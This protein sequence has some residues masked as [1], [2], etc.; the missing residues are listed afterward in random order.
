[1]INNFERF[2]DKYIISSEQYIKL[3]HLLS[4]YGH[5][6]E[7][8]LYP[9]TSYYLDNPKFEFANES[10]LHPNDNQK[11]RIRK[12]D[13][14]N[15]CLNK[16][17]IFE[18][19]ERIDGRIYKKRFSL[20]MFDLFSIS[21]NILEKMINQNFK[22]VYS[23]EK[24]KNFYPRILVQYFREA[25]EFPKYKDLRI[26]FDCKINCYL[27]SSN[28]FNTIITTPCSL[29]SNDKYLLEIKYSNTK[30]QWLENIISSVQIEKT[31]F[32]KYVSAYRMLFDKISG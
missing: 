18:L 7:Y 20:P 29:L 30:P 19:K 2:E 25:Y 6:D 4:I 9:V 31:Y 5:I 23:E 12:Y 26:T 16:S 21:D 32:S 15:L 14:N 1:M 11:Y 22:I 24:L 13:H 28:N 3:K 17:V 10:I 8:G 27:T